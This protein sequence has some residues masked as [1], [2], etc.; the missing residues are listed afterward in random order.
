[1]ADPD[2]GQV[3]DLSLGDKSLDIFV[4][5]GIPIEKVDGNEAIAGLDLP[6]QLP[7][8]CDV[9]A[10]GLFCEDM[11]AV[12][13]RLS[14]LLWPCVSQGE[15]SDHVNRRIVEDG[16]GGFVDGCR[17]DVLARDVSN[18]RIDVVHCGHFP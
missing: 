1:M 12:G 16:I 5:P 3:A 10:K 13:E 11:L 9:G 2:N 6:D 18:R 4:I 14:D 17:R 7:F 8:C 15:Q